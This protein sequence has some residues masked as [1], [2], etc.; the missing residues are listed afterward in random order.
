[1][2]EM[3]CLGEVIE[4]LQDLKGEVTDTIY[5]L[6]FT[7]KGIIAAIVLHYSDSMERYHRPGLLTIFL[8]NGLRRA[9]IKRQ[10][11][12]LIEE[13]RQAF[14]NKTPEEILT[15]HRANV[16]IDYENIISVA[17]KKGLLSASLEFLLQ[18]YPR[19]KIQFSLQNSRIAEVE[20]VINKILPSKVLKTP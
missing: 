12:R 18:N 20:R 8:G 19:K 9:E 16:K 10:S 6:F 4:V 1:M 17:T 15:T 13:R 11:M 2:T 14:K 7:E 5:D 3:K